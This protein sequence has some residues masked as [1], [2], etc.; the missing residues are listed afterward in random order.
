MYG[1]KNRKYSKELKEELKEIYLCGNGTANS[2]AR[3]YDLPLKTVKTW[4][5]Q[6]NHSERFPNLGQKKRKLKDSEID[7]KERYEILKKYQAFL[8]AQRERK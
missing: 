4:I 7:W 2:I 1:Q 6:W 3:D 8:K 5:Y